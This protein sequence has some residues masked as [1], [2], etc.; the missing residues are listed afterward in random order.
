M[1]FRR[2]RAIAR[3]EGLHILRDPRS[4]IAALAMPLLLL[5]LFGYAL[6]LD[7][8]RIPTYIYD[9]DRTPQSRELAARFQGSKYF[10]ILGYVHDYATIERG[11]DSNK[12]LLAVVIPHDFG[13][14][15][16]AG[17][18]AD[19]QVLL[20][21]ADSNT[22]SLAMG[23]AQ[24]LMQTYSMDIRAEA[25]N[26]KA[27]GQL[28]TPVEARIRVW[29]NSDLKSK[30]YIVPGLIA[31]ILMIIAALLTSLTIAREWETGTMEQLLST[32]V[33]P[34]ELVLGK[35]SAFFVLGLIDMA[36]SLFVGVFVFRVPLQ[37]DLLLLFV[38]S[39]I[40]LFG[41]L[42]WGIMLSAVMRSQLLAY[43]MGLLSSFLPAFLLS[44]FI[45][46]IENMP[47]VIQVITFIVPARYFVTILKGIFLKGVGLQVLWFELLL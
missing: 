7:V 47:K 16:L 40:F 26:R 32:P 27:G 15:L 2:Y 22:A 20:D 4:L 13:H 41:A 5:L 6:T 9:Q 29:Y 45:Y 33:R 37:G 38:S 24:S 43:Q 44:G 28:K 11:I 12:A 30:N 46:S 14:R 35:L 19:V 18:K 10:H 39:C 42:C 31:V 8:D 17:Q 3:K 23:Y 34:S 25:Q 21:G 1:S 36:V